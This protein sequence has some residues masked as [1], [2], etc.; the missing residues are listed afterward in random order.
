[1]TCISSGSVRTPHSPSPGLGRPVSVA[2][3]Q[4][5]AT[6]YVANLVSLAMTREMGALMTGVIACGRTSTSFAS[7]LGSMNVS[8]ETDALR[9]LLVFNRLVAVTPDYLVIGYQVLPTGTQH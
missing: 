2:I 3:R 1:M 5:G 8:Q 6:V 4:V 9:S 7:Q